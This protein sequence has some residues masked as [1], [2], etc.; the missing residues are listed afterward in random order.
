MSK[1]GV[2]TCTGGEKYEKFY[3]RIARKNLYQYDYRHIDGKLF[4]T[5]A[6]SLKVCRA[7]RDAW[8]DKQAAN[9]TA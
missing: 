6:P 8:L 7:R 9:F 4:S 5:V 3:S 1:D 2:S